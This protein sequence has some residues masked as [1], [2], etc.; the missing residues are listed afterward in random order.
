MNKA[1]FIFR[2]QVSKMTTFMKAMATAMFAKK[3]KTTRDIDSEDLNYQGP[4][5]KTAPTRARHTISKHERK[6]RE[7]IR[8]LN[9]NRKH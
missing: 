1:P 9:P 6:R 3:E 5:N 8:H 4:I 2:P 7:Q